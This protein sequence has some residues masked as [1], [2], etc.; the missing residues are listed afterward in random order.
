MSTSTRSSTRTTFQFYFA[1]FTSSNHIPILSHELPSVPNTNIK[2][3]GSR[4]DTGLKI[5][6]RTRTKSRT[7]S[8]IWRSLLT[9][10]EPQLHCLFCR[11]PSRYHVAYKN[12]HLWCWKTGLSFSIWEICW[13]MR[14]HFTKDL[15]ELKISY[16]LQ[17]GV[18]YNILIIPS[19]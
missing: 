10:M 15:R 17:S 11:V 16:I 9:H 4:N 5:E 1:G 18:Q 2:S 14:R 19:N 6:N 8:P 3:K 12:Q 7:R 13:C